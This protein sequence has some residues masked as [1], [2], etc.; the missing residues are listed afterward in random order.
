MQ[1]PFASTQQYPSELDIYKIF[2][3]LWQRKWFIFSLV[4]VCATLALLRAFMMQPVYEATVQI[5]IEARTPDIV[6]MK[7]VVTTD[8]SGQDYRYTQ[9]KILKSQALA[10]KVYEA[11][12]G[13]HP[14]NPWFGRNMQSPASD[15]AAQVHALLGCVSIDP[16]PKSELVNITIADVDPLVAAR[17]AQ[18]WALT[19][20]E[21]DIHSKAESTR[22]AAQWLTQQLDSIRDNA[23]GTVRQLDTFRKEHHITSDD[24]YSEQLLDTLF[25]KKAE[26]EIELA[27]QRQYFKDKHPV[28]IGLISELASIQ[29]KI[30]TEEAKILGLNEQAIQYT[31]LKRKQQT[32]EE[33]Y[34]VLLKRAQ[35]TN[36][37]HSLNVSNIRI[38]DNA[39]VPTAPVRPKKAQSLFI[40]LFIGL[41]CGSTVVFI[42]EGMNS[43]IRTSQDLHMLGL[44][45]LAIIPMRKKG[46]LPQPSFM[47]LGEDTFHAEEAFKMLRTA[48]LFNFQEYS[49][50]TILVVSALRGEGK[51]T[52]SVNLAATIA[53]MGEK[54]LLIDADM[55]QPMVHEIFNVPLQQ[56]LSD[57]LSGAL[58]IEEAVK[59]TRIEN[60]SIMTAG[61]R[62]KNPA[63]LL[64]SPSVADIMRKLKNSYDRIIFD[65]TPGLI[66]TDAV[67]TATHVDSVLMVIKSDATN[68]ALA[69]EFLRR[70][71]AVNARIV[72]G[73]LNMV[74]KSSYNAYYS[75]YGDYSA[76]ASTTTARR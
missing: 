64:S 50:H 21:M 70:L 17:I 61:S 45:P 67:I 39:K 43:R 46:R 10:E 52:V 62:S 15:K 75:Y 8:Y 26:L 2:I 35:E 7:D 54:T 33:I 27:K 63:E 66:V 12:S 4:V 16:V 34:K 51:T 14:W 19:Y 49:R 47:V 53:Q 18:A 24:M 30:Q 6:S 71:H 74:K 32:Q 23:E 9:Y 25:S 56:G 11:L 5:I 3:V 60:L 55:R 1:E 37:I 41:F 73:V 57:V 59:Q 58:R 28:M 29:K 48:L 72:G 38:I 20:I 65:G 44:E 76:Y 68:K 13:Y 36:L 69:R 31:M 42:F 40:A 22:F